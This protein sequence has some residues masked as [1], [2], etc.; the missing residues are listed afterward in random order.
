LNDPIGDESSGLLKDLSLLL[1]KRILEVRLLPNSLPKDAF[2]QIVELYGEFLEHDAFI[3][4]YMDFCQNYLELENIVTV[5]AYI[6]KTPN[7]GSDE[8]EKF[9]DDF[10]QDKSDNED[11][12]STSDRTNIE[13]SGSTNKLFQL[14]CVLQLKTVFPSLYTLLQI[15]VTLPVSSCSV[16]R[17]FSKLKLVKTKLRSTM[18]EDR[19]ENVMIIT[20][21]QD[22]EPITER[23]IQ[24]FQ[25]KVLYYQ[26]L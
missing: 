20:C 19:L 5:P 26:N 14:C 15:A 8:S 17:S 10:D 7:Q 23:V 18:T 13:N 9:F 16:E 24:Y 6:H 4:N 11:K 12:A 21:E 1:R 3:R 22:C 25:Q 2:K